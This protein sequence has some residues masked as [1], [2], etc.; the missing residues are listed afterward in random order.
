MVDFDKPFGLAEYAER[1]AK[2]RK[3]MVAAEIDLLV[4]VDPANICWLTGYDSWSFSTPQA[5][6]LHVEE[7]GPVW[8]GRPMDEPAAHITTD[9]PPD[10]IVMYADTLVHRPDVHAFDDLCLL[11]KARGWDKGCIAVEGDA[12]FYSLRSHTHLVKG[13]PEAAFVDDGNLVNWARLVKS[14]AELVLM[15]EAGKICTSAMMRAAE[16]IR[17]GVPQNVVVAEIFHA[18]TMGIPGAGGDYTS[19][20]PLLQAGDSTKTP[21]LT[22][23]DKPLPGDT[24]A[25]L[26]IAG[27]RRRYQVPNT[28]TFYLGKPPQRI[29]DLAK[30]VIEGGDAAL[31]AAKPGVT[32]EE[33]EAIWQAVLRRHG[34]SKDSRVAYSIGLNYPPDWGERTVSFRPGEKTVLEPGMCFHFQS[35][36]WMDDIGA[37]VSESFVVTPSG[38]ERLCN[39][40]RELIVID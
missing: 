26:E 5:V 40:P 12:H 24:L 17:P 34:L 14:E 23:T 38:G 31:A 19:L 11:V 9:L 20:V 39:A 4:S 33:V 29:V 22:W 36:V 37:A 15:R 25:V 30:A 21:H 7:G 27:A 28:R 2:A 32:G 16:T 10:D 13:L 6:L 3:R 35:G 1:I 8:W 18:Q